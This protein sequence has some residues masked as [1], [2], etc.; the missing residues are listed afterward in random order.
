MKKESSA[1]AADVGSIFDGNKLAVAAVDLWVLLISTVRYSMGRRTY[2]TS[3]AWELVQTYNQA[4]TD[5]QLEQVIDEIEKELAIEAGHSTGHMGMACDVES[6][7][8][9]VLELKA[10]LERRHDDGH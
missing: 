2:M 4:L 8:R 5:P 7:K 1:T 10:I 3:L 6:W 9:G